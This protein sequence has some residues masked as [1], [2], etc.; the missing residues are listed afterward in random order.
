MGSFINRTVLSCIN[1][2]VKMQLYVEDPIQ[3][4]LEEMENQNPSENGHTSTASEF[5]R[6][7][8]I[9]SN[10]TVKQDLSRVRQ[11]ESIYPYGG[12]DLSSYIWRATDQAEGGDSDIM[13]LRW[14]WAKEGVFEDLDSAKTLAKE[15]G[16]DIELLE[17]P[18]LEATINNCIE[19]SEKGFVENEVYT[20][21]IDRA[22]KAADRLGGDAYDKIFPI[23]DNA[24]RILLRESVPI[25]DADDVRT[26]YSFEKKTKSNY[27]E[28]VEIAVKSGFDIGKMYQDVLN[29]L[30]A[31]LHRFANDIETYL[32]EN[33]EGVHSD[34]KI[35]A[36]F[37]PS[38]VQDGNKPMNYIEE[39]LDFAHRVATNP[40][41]A[42]DIYTKNSLGEIRRVA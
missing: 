26:L 14:I 37:A 23:Q 39:I 4:M 12:Y 2:G 16:W 11:K 34:D 30:V 27:L 8:T 35:R 29:D 13:G 15:L 21:L 32:S 33:K 10:R 25:Y 19:R 40:N 7:M 18:I 28:A 41:K 9:L 3:E 24:I 38:E 42:R 22:I 36:L 6:D 31:G 1:N 20:G 5:D 17:Q